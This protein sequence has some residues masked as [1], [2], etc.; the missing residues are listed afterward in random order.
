MTQ[1][2]RFPITRIRQVDGGIRT[3]YAASAKGASEA[4]A[5]LA[6]D[7]AMLDHIQWSAIED[8]CD[9]KSEWRYRR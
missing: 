9:G 1:K 5:A 3:I 6:A 8:N 4:R 2:P 7:P